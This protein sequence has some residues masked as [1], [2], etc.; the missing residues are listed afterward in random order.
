MKIFSC[1]TGI[2]NSFVGD[3]ISVDWELDYKADTVYYGVVGNHNATSGRVMRLGINAEAD[4]QI[5]M[6]VHPHLS[7][8]PSQLYQV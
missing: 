6:V 5:G 7:I 2:A 8:M 3:P 4:P 1:D